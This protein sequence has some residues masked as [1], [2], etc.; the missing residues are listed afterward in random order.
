MRG[1]LYEKVGDQ[2]AAIRYYQAAAERTSSV[3]ERNYLLLK[4]ARL[5]ERGN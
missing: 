5:R 2:P 1:H 4:A 3:P